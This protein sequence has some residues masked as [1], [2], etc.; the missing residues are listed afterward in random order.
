MKLA[1][2]SF[3]RIAD[4]IKEAKT[5][6]P[7]VHLMNR[8]S[9]RDDVM[10]NGKLPQL[11]NNG[12]NTSKSQYLTDR[13]S[14]LNGKDDLRKLLEEV[15][16]SH[17]DYVDAINDIISED[18]FHLAENE[19]KYVVE[20]VIVDHQPQIDNT[21]AFKDCQKKI[22][23]ALDDAK[24]SIKVAIAWFTNQTI[25][26]KLKEKYDAGVDVGV[27]IYDDYVNGKYGVDLKDIPCK[28]VKATRGGKMHHK[29]CV[30][31]N[32]TVVTGSYNWSTNAEFKN[33]ENVL[34]SKNANE[35]ATQYTLEYNRLNK[36]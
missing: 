20:G 11:N 6:K 34:I 5:S 36:D 7:W 29:F 3:E 2:S 24:V 10:N 28:F 21:A 33:D 1:N 14:K 23:D 31:D 16:T 32:Q 26:D 15:A 4:A 30:I 35:T 8:Y 9:F 19:G 12:L 18:G 22:L 27:L 13:L 25:A 17:P